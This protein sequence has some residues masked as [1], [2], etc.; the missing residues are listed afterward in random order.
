MLADNQTSLQSVTGGYVYVGAVYKW[1][2]VGTS[3]LAEIAINSTRRKK[4]N[5][6]QD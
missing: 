6:G 5:R 1:I 2:G 3:E 4:A